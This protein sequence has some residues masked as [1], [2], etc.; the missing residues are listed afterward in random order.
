[1]NDKNPAHTPLAIFSEKFDWSK[2]DAV[3]DLTFNEI[4]WQ[5]IK[6]KPAPSPVRAAF[7]KRN[8]KE[9]RGEKGEND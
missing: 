1:L 3:P 9:D 6:G 4:L 2:E 5:G 8:H 7:L